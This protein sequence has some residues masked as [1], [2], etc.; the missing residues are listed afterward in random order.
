MLKKEITFENFE[1]EKETE[2]HYFHLNK[3]ELIE[4]EIKG[5][6]SFK[7]RLQAIVDSN[8]VENIFKEFKEIIL[9]SYGK[10]SED[11]KRFVKDET[12]S[13]EFEQSPAFEALIMEMIEDPNAASA[14]VTAVVPASLNK[15]PS[16][17]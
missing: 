9:M 16:P 10:R 1:G 3:V 4:L 6:R 8:D 17:A 11:G 5:N 15:G 7:D 2:T 13:R 14:F 12:F